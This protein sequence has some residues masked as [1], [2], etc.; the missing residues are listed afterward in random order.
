MTMR[1]II[2]KGVLVFFLL[3]IS[4]GGVVINN[5]DTAIEQK[6]CEDIDLSI[7]IEINGNEYGLDTVLSIPYKGYEG[8]IVVLLQGSGALDMDGTVGEEKY[9]P[10]KDL[11]IGLVKREVAV[12][13]FN[14][15]F[16]QYSFLIS[17]NYTVYDEVLDDLDCILKYLKENFQF[18]KTILLGHSL[19]VTF[20]IEEAYKDSEI[21]AVIS[22]AGSPRRLQELLYDQYVRSYYQNKLLT[23]SEREQKIHRLESIIKKINKLQGNDKTM[24]FNVPASY[25]RSLNEL[26]QEKHIMN[27]DIPLFF[28][29][30]EMDAQ[31]LAEVDFKKWE[32]KLK[33]KTN[34]EFAELAGVN[35]YFIPSGK[36][37]ISNENKHMDERVFDLIIKWIREL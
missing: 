31:V 12:I 19:G 28:L 34:V 16:Y 3:L 25:W 35:H 5:T 32:A 15:R 24:Y 8:P 18:T 37:G 6:V 10:M 17:D 21:D 30:G 23:S 26:Y 2:N 7:P 14:K 20:A 4:F 13:R 29:Q 27:L 22:M 1:K 36:Y 9:K 33:N 11:A